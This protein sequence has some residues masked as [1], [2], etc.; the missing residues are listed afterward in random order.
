MSVVCSVLKR[1]PHLILSGELIHELLTKAINERARSQ[2]L[3][4]T[5]DRFNH[6]DVIR[7][8]NCHRYKHTASACPNDKACVN[9]G[10]SY[11]GDNC[12]EIPRCVNCKGNHRASSITCP[13]Y[14]KLLD[15][16]RSRSVHTN[17]S[18]SSNSH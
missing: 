12:Q 2:N 18:S 14:V 10:G 6:L 16:I 3:T 13:V 5:V 4:F 17:E 8:Y 7:C 1:V 15:T 9:C 11:H